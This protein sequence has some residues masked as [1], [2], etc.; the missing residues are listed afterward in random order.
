MLNYTNRGHLYILGQIRFLD[1][2]KDAFIKRTIGLG[3]AREL[4]VPDSGLVQ[5]ERGFFL[6]LNSH[7]KTGFSRLGLPQHVLQNIWLIENGAAKSIS[8]FI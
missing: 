7:L 1:L 5:R 8:R 6:F 2:A 4:L 3:L